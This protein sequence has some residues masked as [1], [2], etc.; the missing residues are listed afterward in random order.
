MMTKM[1]EP[2]AAHPRP[3]AKLPAMHGIVNQKIRHIS[4]HQ[5]ACGSAG[6]LDVPK[7]R[8]QRK[9]GGKANDACPN[10]RSYEVVWTRVVHPMEI[11]NDSY[12][13]V[14]ETM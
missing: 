2:V 13:M 1:S 5:T 11:P 14:D 3:L 9:E 8:E 7:E 4:E 10:R 6:N 12:L